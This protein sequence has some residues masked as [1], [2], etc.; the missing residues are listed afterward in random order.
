MFFINFVSQ[1][2]SKNKQ[3][4]MSSTFY[5]D[6]C[7]NPKQSLEYFEMIYNPVQKIIDLDNIMQ[8]ALEEHLMSEEDLESDFDDKID[9]NILL[10]AHDNLRKQISIFKNNIIDIPNYNSDKELVEAYKN[11]LNTYEIIILKKYPKVFTLMQKE[12]ISEKEILSFNVL[13]KEI[14]KDLD[15][16]LSE[17]YFHAEEFGEKH[18]IE[19][20]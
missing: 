16:T 19:I 15:I 3:Q 10:K 6:G 20:S 1:F 17:F 7:L 2:F 4:L 5:M 9:I 8:H 18:D 13:L 14:N 12:E 11:L